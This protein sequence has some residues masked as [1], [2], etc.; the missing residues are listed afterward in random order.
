MER[1]TSTLI[2][3]LAGALA[4]PALALGLN[5]PWWLS[6]LVALGVS[7]GLMLTLRPAGFGFN[8]DAMQEAQSDTALGLLE[9]GSA[10][11]DR[12][13]DIAPS[14]QDAG[15]KSAVLALADTSNKIIRHVR[16]DSTRAMAVRRFLTF[17]LPNAAQIAEGWQTLEANAGSPPERKAQAREVM[18][19]LNE[20]AL[21]YSSDADAPELDALD[22]SLRVVKDSLKSDLEKSA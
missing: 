6:L 17:Y 21:K 1:G 9:D 4:F 11:L 5:L 22:L 20:A 3:G 13:R 19:A 8:L 16:K 12:I 18:T 7:G 15:M 2:A 14:I 10:A